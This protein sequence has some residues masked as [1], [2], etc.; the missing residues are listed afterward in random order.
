[1]LPNLCVVPTSTG[2]EASCFSAFKKAV[3]T[4]LRLSR[5][6]KSVT[7]ER[8]TDASCSL[9]SNVVRPG[10]MEVLVVVFML[11]GGESARG[12]CE[13][14][15]V[16]FQIRSHFTLHCENNA[17]LGSDDA[18]RRAHAS[19]ST[20]SSNA[21][22]GM[23][24]R[25]RKRKREYRDAN[26]ANA[27]EAIPG[28]L[29]DIVITHVLRSEYF[30]DPADLARLP[31]VSRGMRDAVAETGLQFKEHREYEALTLGCLSAVQR[32]QR[33]GRLSRQ[34]YLCA[35]A[36]R[37]GQLEEL[38]ALRAD[39]WPWDEYTCAEAAFGGHLEVLQWARA[40]GCPWGA[41]T[42]MFA[43]SGG[44]LEVLQWL[45]ENGCPWVEWTCAAAARGGHL[46]VL[47]CLRANG[48]PWDGFTCRLALQGGHIGVFWWAAQNG[49]PRPH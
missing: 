28:L 15:V 33:Q 46:E 26:A 39:G 9:G 22:I 18:Q 13:S 41:I 30:D 45:R 21:T 7:L 14:E 48:C 24:T 10:W 11:G 49:A 1:M 40:N 12:K 6:L 4:A 43:A 27:G 19:R 47:K 17:F 3:L 5:V 31:V 36:A 32:L 16:A 34:E 20:L 35:A 29:N 2:V 38:Q 25:A 23:E 44:H 8:N 42:C 37:S